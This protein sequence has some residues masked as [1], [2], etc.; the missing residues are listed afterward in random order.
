MNL[1][2]TDSTTTQDIRDLAAALESTIAALLIRERDAEAAQRLLRAAQVMAAAIA[3][4]E[5]TPSN[6]DDPRHD[7]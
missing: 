6:T 4:G 7:A 5:A 3:R 2:T 1:N